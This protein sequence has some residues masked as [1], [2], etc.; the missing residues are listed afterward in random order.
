M[1]ILF[2]AWLYFLISS[3]MAQS[4]TGSEERIK[5]LDAYWAE[6]S[7]SV[8]EGDFQGYKATCHE[9]GVLVSGTNNSSYPLSDALARWKK[10]F[11]ATKEGKIKA[12]VEFRFSQR[13]GDTTTAHETGIFLYSSGDPGENSK[14]EYIHFQA[15]LVKRKGSWK[16]M[17]EYQKSKASQ[18]EWNE[19]AVK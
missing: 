9:E 3:C 14:D 4:G 17:M 1:K 10:D 15:L 7:R 2:L 6:V 18:A 16:I 19:L 5:E 12:S 8:R 11:T 13:I